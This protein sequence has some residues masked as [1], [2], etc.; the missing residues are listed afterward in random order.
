MLFEKDLPGS[1]AKLD[2]LLAELQERAGAYKLEPTPRPRN[3]W[4]EEEYGFYF[5]SESGQV[6]LW[7]GIWMKFWQQFGFPLCFGV[8]QNWPVP[9]REAFQSAY[10]GQTYQLDRWT[11]GAVSQ[12]AL[13]AATPVDTI[14]GQLGPIVDAVTRVG[15]GKQL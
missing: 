1:L 14:W 3:L 11:L 12:Q 7:F 10:S 2:R 4:P 15:S 8:D 13:L 5:K 6:V 9:I